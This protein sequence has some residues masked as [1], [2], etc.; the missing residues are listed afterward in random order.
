MRTITFLLLGLAFS[1]AAWAGSAPTVP[2][3]VSG[4]ASNQSGADRA[5]LWRL[6]G[7][8]PDAEGRHRFVDASENGGRTWH[9]ILRRPSRDIVRIT[10]TTARNGF[11]YVDADPPVLATSTNGREVAAA[12]AR[13]ASGLDARVD[14]ARLSANH[15]RVEHAVTNV[16]RAAGASCPAR[17][18]RVDWPMIRIVAPVVFAPGWS[19]RPGNS[20]PPPAGRLPEFMA[21]IV[22]S[23][24][25]KTGSTISGDTPHVVVVHVAP[26]YAP[27]PGHPG[28]GTVVAVVC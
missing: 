21:V 16:P 1:A 5:H 3:P 12:G 13:D 9:R 22:S 7:G 20:P 19:T 15:S 27:N 28:K 17:V 8:P 10:R 26:G 14:I 6:A 25:T 23:S 2:S 4:P 11:V 18:F 24:I